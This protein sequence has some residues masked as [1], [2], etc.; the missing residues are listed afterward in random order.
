VD[1]MSALWSEWERSSVERTL[2]QAI[3]GGPDTVRRA[4][5]AFVAQTG[6]DELMITSHIY[7]HSARLRSYEILAGVVE[8]AEERM[9]AGAAHR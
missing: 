7:D 1:D 2:R 9:S 3:V 4:L 8:G 5:D 6:A